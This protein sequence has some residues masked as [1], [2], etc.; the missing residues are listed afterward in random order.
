MS[1]DMSSY[2]SDMVSV[3]LTVRIY[4]TVV[5]LYTFQL[6]NYHGYHNCVVPYHQ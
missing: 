1:G 4:S 6:F 5:E 2:V 3:E